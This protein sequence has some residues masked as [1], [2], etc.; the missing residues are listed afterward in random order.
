MRLVVIVPMSNIVRSLRLTERGYADLAIQEGGQMSL[1]Y[2][3]GAWR[4]GPCP[5]ARGKITALGLDKRTSRRII[6]QAALIMSNLR[7]KAGGDVGW[8]YTN[9]PD[10]DQRE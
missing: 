7:T 3:T 8:G 2:P 5:L 9:Q 4:R 10:G 6:P 1:E